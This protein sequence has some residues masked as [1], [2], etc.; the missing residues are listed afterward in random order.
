MMKSAVVIGIVLIVVAT[1]GGCSP[2][3]G[4]SSPSGA[5]VITLYDADPLTITAGESVT[6][7]WAVTDATAVSIDQGIGDV[8]LT[9]SRAVSPVTTTVYTLVATGSG[10]RTAVATVEILVSVQ[11]SSTA[12]LPVIRSFTANPPDVHVGTACTLTWDVSNATS[13]TMDQGIGS[14]PTSGSKSVTPS[15]TTNYTLTAANASGS[16]QRTVPVLVHPRPSVGEQPDLAVLEIAKVEFANAYRIT[17]L[18]ANRGQGPSPATTATLYAN[19]V[20]KASAAVQPLAAGASANTEFVSWVYD[21]V[22]PEIR[23]VVDPDNSVLEADEDNNHMDLTFPVE[24][25][26][27]FIAKAEYAVWGSGNSGVGGS[28]SILEFGG[29][30]YAQAGY[31]D[32][33]E[34]EILEDG[35][36]YGVVLK[37][38][39]DWGNHG[40][41]EGHFPKVTLPVGAKFVADVGFLAGSSG[42]KGATF[43]VWYFP[44]QGD[45]KLFGTIEA[46]WDNRLDRFEIDLAEFA[47]TTGTIG[48]GVST[49]AL[50]SSMGPVWVGAKIIH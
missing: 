1:F 16:V 25:V 4:A 44:D 31:V 35:E 9:G 2:D 11:S 15:V 40:W 23:V 24:T 43:G 22:T 38:F 26:L 41:V 5:P 8:A 7:R 17:C 10:G 32:W 39:P 27:D 18:I 33:G 13:L 50:S 12:G 21:P 37:T 46:V 34:Y 49:G 48:I 14:V 47:G 30:S 28:G 29:E 42:T 6:L 36:H 45:P 3:H 20:Q 19:G